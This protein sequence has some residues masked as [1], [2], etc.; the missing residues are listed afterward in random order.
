M[1]KDNDKRCCSIGQHELAIHINVRVM[2]VC[3]SPNSLG[4]RILKFLLRGFGILLCSLRA[5]MDYH[6]FCRRVIISGVIVDRGETNRSATSTMNGT[7]TF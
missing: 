1:T 6:R 7:R 5:P 4:G 3:F 2:S